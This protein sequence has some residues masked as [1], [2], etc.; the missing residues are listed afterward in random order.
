MEWETESVRQLRVGGEGLGWTQQWMEGKTGDRAMAVGRCHG[1]TFTLIHCPRW[2]MH[3]E[4]GVEKVGGTRKEHSEGE[5]ASERE[6]TFIEHLLNTQALLE[7]YIHK[8]VRLLYYC[9]FT[10]V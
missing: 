10:S 6:L 3:Q 8:P 5:R 2:E 4:R 9:V 7:F 1:Q